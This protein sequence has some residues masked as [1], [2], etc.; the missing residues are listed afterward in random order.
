MLE[1][2]L[3]GES[4]YRGGGVRTQEVEEGWCPWS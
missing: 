3:F 2:T 1:G 4:F